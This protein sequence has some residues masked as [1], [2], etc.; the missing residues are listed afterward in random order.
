MGLDTV[1]IVM[2]TERTFGI[3]ISD[4]DAAQCRTVGDLHRCVIRLLEERY[5]REGRNLIAD[6]R[7]PGIRSSHSSWRSRACGLIRCVLRPNG[8]EISG[9]ISAEDSA[10]AGA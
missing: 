9:L 5:Q 8:A 2:A 10:G 3:D 1:E 6:R 4:A 7:L